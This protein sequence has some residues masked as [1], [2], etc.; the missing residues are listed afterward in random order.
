MGGTRGIVD[1]TFI[2]HIAEAQNDFI[3][4]VIGSQ[5]GCLVTLSVVSLCILLNAKTCLYGCSSVD[6]RSKYILGGAI[7]N[8]YV[9]TIT[10]YGN[11]CWNYAY[12]GH[13]LA[14]DIIG[15][16]IPCFI[17]DGTSLCL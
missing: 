6:S 5:F 14:F 7:R 11:A 13:Y 12:Y 16:I 1:S 2:V 15:W 9:P 4:S 10:E 8:L 3:F 17:Y